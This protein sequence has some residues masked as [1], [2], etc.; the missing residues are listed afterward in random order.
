MSQPE[1]SERSLLLISKCGCW[2]V[3]LAQ[4]K[5]I[6]LCVQHERGVVDL[7]REVQP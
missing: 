3:S 4:G 1:P 6:L 5:A 2:I 7:I